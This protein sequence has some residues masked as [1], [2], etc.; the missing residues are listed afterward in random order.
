MGAGMGGGS[1]N[2]ASALRGLNALVRRPLPAAKLIG[3]AEQLGS[4]VPFFL[5][6]GTALGLGRGTELYPLPDQRSH[7][8]LVLAT[9]L[10][11]STAEAY[12]GLHRQVNQTL[13][14]GDDSPILR[15]FQST[16]WALDQ[17]ALRDLP[18]QNDF[19]ESVFEAHPSLRDLVRL[20]KRLGARPALMT[21][22]GSAVFGVFP[23]ME[24]ARAAAGRFAPGTAH[25]VRFLT[26]RQHA[27]AWERSLR[28][29]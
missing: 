18:L 9:G 16:T 25:A 14:Q 29:H 12:R 10:H 11:V 22:S 2:A 20:L 4:D 17:A 24:A 28:L 6:G 26:R 15:E 23:T 13:T 21:G 19:E 1:S 3:L 7:P 8:V 27:Q 5:R